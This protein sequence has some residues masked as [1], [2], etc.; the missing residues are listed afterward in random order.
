MALSA[1][2][3]RMLP[4]SAFALP[5]KRAYPVRNEKEA[6]AALSYGARFASKGEYRRIENTVHRRFPDIKIHRLRA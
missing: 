1:K 2:Q 6:H 4:R 3:R 5:E